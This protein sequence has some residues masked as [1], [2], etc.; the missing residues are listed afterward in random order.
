MTSAAIPKVLNIRS[1]ADVAFDRLRAP[2][3]PPT[4][5]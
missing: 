4:C 1:A 2:C 5:W 3:E